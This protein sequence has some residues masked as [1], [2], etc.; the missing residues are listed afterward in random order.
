MKYEEALDYIESI[1]PE[2]I[3]PGLDSIRELCRELGNPQDEL[4]FVH[5]AGT[6]GKGSVVSFISKV[7]QKAGYKTGTFVSPVIF[8]FRD[9]I[10]VNSKPITKKALGEEMETVKNACD[11]MV[12]NGFSRP[13]P[14][15]VE[16][17][18]AFLHFKNA[19]CDIVVLETG[20]GGKL[21]ATNIIKN[22]LVCVFTSIALDHMQFLGN[23][24]LEIAKN[25]SGII[26]PGASVLIEDQCREVLAVMKENA[27]LNRCYFDVAEVED[28]TGVRS[29]LQKQ[30]F[31]YKNRKKISISMVGRYQIMNACV[32]LDA[33]DELIK[34]GFNISEKAIFSGLLEAS[35]PGRF[36]I[37]QKKPLIIADGAHNPDGAKR[38]AESIEFYFT[39]KRIV[40]IMGMLKDKDYE[41]VIALTHK[42]ADEIIT[43]TPPNNERALSAYELATEIGKVHKSVSAVDSVEEALEV[44][45][46]MCGRDGIIIAFGSLS[47]LGRLI[48]DVKKSD[49]KKKIVI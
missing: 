43:I 31:N 4:K 1:K 14:F 10:C 24:V 12:G 8:D 40:Y 7:L 37:I 45:S 38:L 18:L 29:G 49:K 27:E 23:T 48:G 35:V 17:A 34:K 13:T 39:N 30:T 21:D 22:T 42:Y 28:I 2:G 6:N 47:Y 44:A 33:I 19:G 5:V 32:S 9:M 16:T 46:L 3:K 26:K 20:M 25:K 11:K 41:S 36:Q 15:E